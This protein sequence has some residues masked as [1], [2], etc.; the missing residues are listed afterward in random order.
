MIEEDFK[1]EKISLNNCIQFLSDGGSEFS[2]KN[3]GL[4]KLLKDKYTNM[5]TEVCYNHHIHNALGDSLKF[6]E[7]P[8]K[9]IK[10]N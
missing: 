3:I 2:G 10:E 5:A 4:H 7:E 8:Y 9:F 1:K 6:L